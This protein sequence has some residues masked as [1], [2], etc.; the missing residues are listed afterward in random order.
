VPRE[1]QLRRCAHVGR[2]GR[3]DWRA[4]DCP[5][6]DKDGANPAPRRRRAPSQGTAPGTSPS[7]RRYIGEEDASRT[8]CYLSNNSAEP[9]YSVVVGL[10]F[11]QGAGPRS[12]EDMLAVNRKQYNRRGPVTTVN[13]LPGGLYRAWIDGTG[14]HRILS[15][16]AGVDIGFTDKAGSHWIRRATGQIDELDKPPLEYLEEW[17]FHGPHDFQTAERVPV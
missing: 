16:R 7:R 6:A 13:I 17:D 3:N 15:G 4:W 14:W 9:V 12:L 2:G 8:A 10:V 11:V 1:R 5:L